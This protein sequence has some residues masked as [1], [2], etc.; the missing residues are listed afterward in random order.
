M[1]LHGV[2]YENIRP[3]AVRPKLVEL[4]GCNWDLEKPNIQDDGNVARAGGRVKS[5]GTDIVIQ[6]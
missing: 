1:N 3:T 6:V 2:S 4:P 5:G